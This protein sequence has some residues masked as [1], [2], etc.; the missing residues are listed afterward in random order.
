MGG[1]PGMDGYG[2]G[3]GDIYLRK[4]NPK[5]Q[6]FQTCLGVLRLKGVEWGPDLLRDT[7]AS[8]SDPRN[9]GTVPLSRSSFRPRGGRP[10][11][12]S[13]PDRSNLVSDT[14]Y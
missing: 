5:L 11:P 14:L 3:M 9:R 2:V 7:C 10:P 6:L 12:E 8:S 13:A 1:R 4:S